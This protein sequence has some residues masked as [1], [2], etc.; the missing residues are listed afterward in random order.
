M[1][2][3]TRRHLL[4]WPEHGVEMAFRLIPAGQFRMGSRDKIEWEEP[5]HGVKY[6]SSGW[7]RRR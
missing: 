7:A 2:N 3:T 4:V 6:R 5:V 1:P